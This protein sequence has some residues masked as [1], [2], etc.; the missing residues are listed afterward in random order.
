MIGIVDKSKGISLA[1]EKMLDLVEISPNAK[2][3]VCRILD[4]GKYKYELTK[5]AHEAKKRQKVTEIKEVRMRPNIAQGDLDVKINNTKRFIE[6]GNKVK[7]SLFFKGRE[8]THS[9]I[10]FQIMDKFKNEVST[11][12]KI[13]ADVR[14]EGKQVYIIVSPNHS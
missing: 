8:I 2:P 12:A 6:D 7:V 11:F 13:E 4:F 5:K 3:P 10:G 1:K 14:K 9:E